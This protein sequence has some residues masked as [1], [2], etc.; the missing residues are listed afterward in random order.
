MDVCLTDIDELTPEAVESWLVEG[1]EM[2]VH[3]N[4]FTVRLTPLWDKEELED[5]FLKERLKRG[6][7]DA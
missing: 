7:E 6:E 3:D 2:F 4:G 1:V 5:A